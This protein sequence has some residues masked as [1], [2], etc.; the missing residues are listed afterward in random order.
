MIVR[1]GVLA[2][3]PNGPSRGGCLM[4]CTIY[5]MPDIMCHIYLYH[6]FYFMYQGVDVICHI[7][8]MSCIM[9]HMSCHISC[10]MCHVMYLLEGQGRCVDHTHTSHHLLYLNLEMYYAEGGLIRC[11]RGWVDKVC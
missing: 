10:I 1:E 7:S 4:S 11:V 8:C 3:A 2:P 5:H 9:C 6:L